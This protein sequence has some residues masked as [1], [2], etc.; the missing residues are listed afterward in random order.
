[1][2]ARSV[3]MADSLFVWLPLWLRGNTLVSINVV[4]CPV[5][6]RMGDHLRT[7][8]PPRHITRHPGPL[9]LSHPSMGRPHEYSAKAG[10][11]NR[12]IHYTLAHICRLAIFA[13]VWLRVSWWK[14]VP[15]YGKQQCIRGVFAMMCYTNAHLLTYLQKS[16]WTCSF[17]LNWCTA[18]SA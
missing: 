4:P 12:I 1:M 11:V 6:A 2:A 3:R 7:G 14:S 8:K 16:F 18:F 10:E 13:G 5:S 17:T 15:I 9:S